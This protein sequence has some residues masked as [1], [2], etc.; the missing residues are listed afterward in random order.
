MLNRN[1]ERE[2]CYV[3]TIDSL[4]PI[5]GR[6]FVECAR[7]G[8]WTVMV[9]KS[10]FTVG[11]PA[12]YFEVDSRTPAKEPFMFLKS[13]GFKIKTQKYKNF[14]SQGLLM[15]A[16][17]F[18]W[19]VEGNKIIDSDGVAHC[20]EDESRFLT[21]QLGVTYA[22][23]EDNKRKKN[24]NKYDLM[25]RRLGKKGSH[26]PIRWLAKSTL[27]KKILFLFYGRK[28]DKRGNWPSHICSKTDTERIENEPFWFENK[29]PLVASEKVDGCSAT[30]AA[31]RG[32]FGR[33]KHYIC[34]RNVVFENPDQ[35]NYYG[36]MIGKNIYYE[37]YVKYDIERIIDMI[38]K[39][40]M[41]D[42]VAIQCEIYGNGVQKR[43]YS[44]PDG[45]RRIAV[46]HIV[47]NR[48]RFTMDQVVEICE[49]YGLPHVDIIDDEFVMPDTVE[50]LREYV[51]STPS[52]ID[53]K[54]KEGIVFY[55]KDNG[56]SFIKCVSPKYL[57][58]Y[59]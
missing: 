45:E 28:E 51:D 24:L 25:L 27:G 23:A 43:D 52:V 13:K 40:Y 10:E 11:A 34:S 33:I 20:A 54:M 32:A 58:K 37:A 1:A 59:H 39:D 5:E 4:E 42:N 56:N 18:G 26:W 16:S 48:N 14:Y 12:V 17:D 36:D 46:F 50:E 22:D 49:R 31:E 57:L 47:S 30:F 15:P 9:R 3:V 19:T 53:G 7:V 44:L 38:L 29:E 6:D 55:R 2:L 8:G 35:A 21:K 41:L